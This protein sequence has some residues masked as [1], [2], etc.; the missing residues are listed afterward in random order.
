[1]YWLCLLFCIAASPAHGDKMLIF[2]DVEQTDHLKAYGVAYHAIEKGLTVEWL[3]NYR[4]GSF[5][6]DVNQ[7]IGEYALVRG[8]AYKIIGPA[9]LVELDTTIEN[10]NMSKELL[11]KAPKVAVYTPPNKQPWDD[12]VTLALTYAEIPY[13]TLWDEEVLG[14]KLKEYD[15]LHLHHE[16]FTGQ[17]GKFYK[18][19]R[20]IPWYIEQQKEFE[21]MAHKLGFAKV[22]E[23]KKAVAEMIREFVNGGGFLFAMCSATD[24]IDIALAA[25]GVDIVAAEFDGDPYDPDY[26]SKLDF[27]R[28]FAFEN[29]HLITDPMIYE[30]SDIDIETEQVFTTRD[31]QEPMEYFEIFE[32]SAKYDPVPT[33]L[34]QDHE[35][36]IKGFMG[37][38]T[39]FHENLIKKNVVI[40]G[41]NRARSTARYIHGNLGEG[42]F[43]FLGGHDPED[44]RHFVNDPPTQLFLHKNSAGYRLIL[45]NVLF[46]G[47][48]KKELKT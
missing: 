29:F 33:M 21:A 20:N 1:M 15:W 28:T 3:L 45:N 14:G 13:D 19:F 42:T 32:F 17:Y 6:I 12:A 35:N 40:M 47:A 22:S 48:K 37:Q 18:N 27:S 31:V 30:F 25:H 38:T 39:E 41:R 2:M 43:T 10:S 44:F 23:E 46:P 36:P 16:D 9:E 7:E 11:E 5:L 4:G 8:V 24:T 34:T 26:Q